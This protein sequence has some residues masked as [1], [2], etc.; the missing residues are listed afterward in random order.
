[1]KKL[2]HL[3]IGMIMLIALTIIF[4]K[5]ALADVDYDITNVDVTAHVNTNGS[6]LMERRIIYKFDDDAHGVFYQQN[7]TN[8]QEL[9]NQQVRIISGKNS[10]PVVQSDSHANNTYE[11]SHG[12]H[13]Y[14]FKVWHNVTDGDKFTVIYTYEI[15]NAIIN[16]K[17]TAELNFKIIGDGWDTDLDNVRVGIFFPGPVKDLKAWAHGDLSGQITV[18]PEKG[19]IIMTAANVSGNEGIEVHSLFPTAVTSQ[20]KNIRDQNHK[21]YVL[22]QEAK[23]AREANERRQ[24]SRIFGLGALALS[25]LFSLFIIIKSFTLKK[26]GVKPK[27]EKQLPRNYDLPRVSPVMA[28]ILDIDNKP[29]SRSLTAYLME[30]AVQ[31]RIE[32]DPV[33]VRRKTYYKISLTDKDLKDEVPL[34]RYLFNK[35]GDGKSFTTYELKKHRSSKL[36]KI[37]ASW[38]KQK[39]QEAV[40]AG[41]L[42]KQIESKKDTNLVLMIILLVLSGAGIIAAFFSSEGAAGLFIAAVILI[43]VAILATIYSNKKL[44]PYTDKGAEATNQV[45]GFKKMLDEIGNFKMR[46]V[47]EMPLWEKIMPYAVALGVSKK[48]LKQLKIE[49]ADE[50]DD[51]NI[52]FW[53]PFYSSGQDGFASNFNSSFNSGANLNS[54]ASGGSGGFSGG[55]SGGFG[56]GSG[57]GAF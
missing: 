44:S 28:E 42:D 14:R 46:E 36:S 51:A 16:W 7:L 41:F 4:T 37:F 13:G 24:R 8:N 25:G 10:Q 6:L 49:F 12:D 18:N 19:N 48:V 1:M 21:K 3:I 40:S 9:K 56:G 30:L 43:G 17:D 45:R 2:F 20:N 26:S 38:Q 15:T 22:N 34:I 50:I 29:S 57:G 54:S 5:P 55:S 39:K 23:F 31:K 33:K 35:V 47:G 53:G 11:L 27:K 52:L 32:I